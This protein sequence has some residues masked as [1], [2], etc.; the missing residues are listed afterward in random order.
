[1]KCILWVLWLREVYYESK[2][3]RAEKGHRGSGLVQHPKTLQICS[4][5]TKYGVLY[6][7]N[8]VYAPSYTEILLAYWQYSV[9][10]QSFCDDNIYNDTYCSG[11]SGLFSQYQPV[12]PIYRRECMYIEE[13]T[14]NKARIKATTTI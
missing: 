6:A 2:S 13:N 4:I 7:V 1:M 11:Q 5:A 12:A 9:E 8:D 10:K 3:D 14:D